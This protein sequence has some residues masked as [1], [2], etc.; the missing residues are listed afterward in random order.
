MIQPSSIGAEPEHRRWRT[1]RRFTNEVERRDSTHGS[2][3]LSRDAGHDD[4]DL[5]RHLDRHP[6]A[7]V[8]TT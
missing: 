3:M 6:A 5:D 1:P 2:V 7:T 8:T 4:L